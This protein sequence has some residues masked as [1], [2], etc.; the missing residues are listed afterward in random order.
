MAEQP[1]PGQFPF[2]RGIYREGYRSRL[3]TKRPYAGFGSAEESN[4]RYR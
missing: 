2:T 4:A 1:E 3:W